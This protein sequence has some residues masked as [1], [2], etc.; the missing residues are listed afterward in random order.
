MMLLGGIVAGAFWKD[1]APMDF[2]IDILLGSRTR[3]DCIG[4][5]RTNQATS[6]LEAARHKAI[7]SK[8]QRKV[9]RNHVC[10]FVDG[11]AAVIRRADKIR[12][13]AGWLGR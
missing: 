4:L 10:S 12:I 8:L 1:N 13:G 3:L 2:K 7:T 6:S 5:A 9:C 11:R